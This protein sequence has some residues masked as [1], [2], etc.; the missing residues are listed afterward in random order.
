MEIIEKQNLSGIIMISIACKCYCMHHD[1]GLG[2][3]VR[4][5]CDRSDL[6]DLREPARPRMLGTGRRARPAVRG[7]C[8]CCLQQLTAAGSTPRRAHH[9]LHALISC[10][11]HLITGSAPS[12]RHGGRE[13]RRFHLG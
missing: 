2:L 9:R 7:R 10:K 1:T 6:L 13:P 12:M 11:R 3:R 4:N 5:G 8:A